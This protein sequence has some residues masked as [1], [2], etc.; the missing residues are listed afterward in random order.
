MLLTTPT[1]FA[2][3]LAIPVT[4]QIP[5]C[6][7]PREGLRHLPAHPPLR[8]A[9]GDAEVQDCPCGVTDDQE[10]VERAEVDSGEVKRPLESARKRGRTRAIRGAYQV[11]KDGEFPLMSKK[12]IDAKAYETG[13][14]RRGARAIEPFEFL[15]SC[16]LAST[17][18]AK[19]GFAS[20]WRV[21]GAAHRLVL[22]RR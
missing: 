19:R 13:F 7:G 9:L 2:L 11:L 10:N 22:E 6:R 8:G 14:A 16:V 15:L 20:V 12:E 3:E 21:S 18:E 4:D 1:T 17:I 5:R